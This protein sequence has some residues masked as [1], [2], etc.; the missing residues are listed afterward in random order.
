MI[1]M[2]IDN[3]KLAISSQIILTRRQSCLFWR[4]KAII[5]IGLYH[6][7][8]SNFQHPTVGR[9]IFNMLHIGWWGPINMPR[10]ISTNTA[11]IMTL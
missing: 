5:R 8:S 1:T 6:T 11:G 9:Q 10:H 2:S 3:P 4:K 7:K